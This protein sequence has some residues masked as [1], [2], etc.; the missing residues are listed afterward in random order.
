MAKHYTFSKAPIRDLM[1]INGPGVNEELH[2]EVY[3]LFLSAGIAEHLDD[4][5]EAGLAASRKPKPGAPAPEPFE[6]RTYHEYI[7]H[8]LTR[9]F[10]LAGVPLDHPSD[11]EGL[12]LFNKAEIS[13]YTDLV[14]MAERMKQRMEAHA[15]HQG[16]ELPDHWLVSRYTNE[17]DSVAPTTG[18][19]ATQPGPETEQ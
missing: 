5:Y 18:E 8:G 12:T 2:P 13:F 9:L 1:Q 7:R 4:A 10:E 11:K 16:I 6:L 19:G 15:E 17:P 3:S 14:T